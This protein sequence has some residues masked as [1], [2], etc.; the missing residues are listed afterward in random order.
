MSNTVHPFPAKAYVKHLL[1]FT[2]VW[3]LLTKFAVSSWIIGIFVVPCAAWLS[4]W[5]FRGSTHITAMP[6]QKEFSLDHFKLFR[7]IPFFIANS[8]KGGINTAR[9]AIFLPDDLSPG[10][11]Q[12]H[13]R[14]PE[15]RPRLW[16]LHMISL[17]PG[18]L[19]VQLQKE[20]LLVHMLSVNHDNFQ[21]IQTC[22]VY[23]AELFDLP[24]LNSSD[25]HGLWRVL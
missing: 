3:V 1:I 18:T 24:N 15:G 5:L 20:C 19:S 7:L 9:L 12:Y 22:E 10:F 17:L 6:L 25:E 16:F 4:L 8:I 11:A 13:L 21:D 23:I 2:V 14:L